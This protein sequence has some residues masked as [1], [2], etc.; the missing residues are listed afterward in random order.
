MFSLVCVYLYYV[1]L[2][3][4]SICSVFCISHSY[5]NSDFPSPSPPSYSPPDVGG[6]ANLQG[7]VEE[8]EPEL[9]EGKADLQEGVDVLTY[10][11]STYII[12]F[13]A[14]FL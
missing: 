11:T 1:P 5:S 2:D 12:P 3:K 8:P 9:V 10:P 6:D 7:G 13:H 4:I 14:C